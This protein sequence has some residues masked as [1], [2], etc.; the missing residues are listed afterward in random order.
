MAADDSTGVAQEPAWLAS[1][2]GARVQIMEG[3]VATLESTHGRDSVEA[4]SARNELAMAYNGIG[5]V[6][7]ALTVLEE[8]S[9]RFRETVGDSLETLTAE[10]NLAVAYHSGGRLAEATALLERTLPK[11]VEIAGPHAVTTLAAQNNLASLLRSLGDT[12]RAIALL[13]DT[14]EGYEQALGKLHPDTLAARNNLAS[15]HL[16]KGDLEK[17]LNLSEKASEG[18]R[19]V[20]GEGHPD[21]LRALN[22]LAVIYGRAGQPDK[23]VGLHKAV[24]DE[25]RSQQGD[26]HSD[27][28]RAV[29]NLAKSY[30]QSG[31]SD[32][33]L[34]VLKESLAAMNRENLEGDE[35]KLPT[36][37]RILAILLQLNRKEELISFYQG[38]FSEDKIS[39]LGLEGHA[40]MLAAGGLI[41]ALAGRGAEGATFLERSADLVDGKP[42]LPTKGGLL[43]QMLSLVEQTILNKPAKQVAESKIRGGLNAT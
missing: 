42:N 39:R 29:N 5:E 6:Q 9:K 21:T 36:R 14:V 34:G 37:L 27:V 30:L 7:K 32:K 28:V 33:A 26:T 23:A 38:E 4:L 13:Q 2:P 25:R 16:A 10:T 17:A 12:D 40:A 43:E 31:K 15:V 1:D 8:N 24:L 19:A 3:R 41:F 35:E 20:L 18:Y 11:L 22:N